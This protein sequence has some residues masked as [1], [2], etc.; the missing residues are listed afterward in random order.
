M[1]HF[2]PLNLVFSFSL[3]VS[4]ITYASHQNFE[5]R[6]NEIEREILEIEIEAMLNTFK[7][8]AKD[9]QSLKLEQLHLMVRVKTTTDEDE[10]I[11][12][13]QKLS[14]NHLTL[15]LMRELSE[16]TRKS[17]EHRAEKIRE[18]WHHG[19]TRHHEREEDHDGHHEMDNEHGSW[20]DELRK[21]QHNLEQE[22]EELH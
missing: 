19:E 2:S 15:H 13:E 17:I 12:V 21:K 1:Q 16:D 7:E 10:R 9:I 8:L 11:S 22:I 3:L 20:T 14:S 18:K 6:S 5:N 4:S